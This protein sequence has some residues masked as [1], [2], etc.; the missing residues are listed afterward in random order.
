MDWKHKRQSKIVKATLGAAVL[1]T[2]LGGYGSVWAADNIIVDGTQDGSQN[3][4]VVAD[5]TARVVGTGNTVNEG[6][7]EVKIVGDGNTVTNSDR[8]LIFGDDN[9]IIDR[10]IADTNG[11]VRA[12]NVSDIIVGK[13]NTIQG[14]A[15]WGERDVS[16]TIIGNNNTGMGV[17]SGVVIGDNQEIS[18]TSEAVIIGALSA[19][20]REQG[21]VNAAGYNV[22][23]G[24]GTVNNNGRSV[25]IGHRAAAG[26]IDQ[27]VVGNGATFERDAGRF[28]SIYGVHNHVYLSDDTPKHNP[29]NP[30]GPEGQ[31][32]DGNGTHI[33]GAFNNAKAV[34]LALIYG[35]GNSVSHAEGYKAITNE[36]MDGGIKMI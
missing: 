35:S 25:V 2:L 34:N 32:I 29:D 30:R 31:P 28:G 11:E 10:D 15:T 4:A 20:Q 36:D 33:I 6:S 24:Y 5:K 14:H 21:E 7:E 12:N 27:T 8:E 17:V 9:S 23:I 16:A 26:G 3:P 1:G 19:E 13:G 18:G 22:V